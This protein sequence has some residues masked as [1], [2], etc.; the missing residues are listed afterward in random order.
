MAAVAGCGSSS[1]PRKSA[2]NLTAQGIRFASCMRSH[3]VPNFP[4]PTTSGRGISFKRSAG[5]GSP[6]FNAAQSACGHLLGGGGT[7]SGNSSAAA[8]AQM[9]AISE[10][11]RAHGISS[12]PDPSTGPP[13]TSAP[14][15]SAFEYNDGAFLAV[16]NSLDAQSPA[17]KHAAN[18]CHFGPPNSGH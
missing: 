10:C 18:A 6:A 9:L 17:F 14:D 2:S 12:F 8:K 16:P 11:M 13:P 15:D 5:T 3:G 7:G 1:P 4:D